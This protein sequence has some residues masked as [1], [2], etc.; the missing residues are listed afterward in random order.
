MVYPYSS[1]NCAR[2]GAAAKG[3]FVFKKTNECKI[4]IVKIDPKRPQRFIA[5]WACVLHTHAH[6]HT[7][8][9]THTGIHTHKHT[10]RRRKLKYLDTIMRSITK[11][12]R[13][14]I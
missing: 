5:V 10:F 9:H 7:H 2:K 11:D 14:P 4:E 13:K 8:T 1:P 6:T 3:T 12:P